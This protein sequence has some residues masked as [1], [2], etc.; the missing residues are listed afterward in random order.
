MLRNFKRLAGL[1]LVISLVLSVFPQAIF[2]SNVSSNKAFLSF[3]VEGNPGVI[4]ESNHTI[5]VTVPYRSAVNNMFESFTISGASVI[6]HTSEMTRTNYTNP[7]VLTVVAEDNSTQD[8]TVTVIIGPSNLKSIT[9]FN[10]TNPPAMGLIDDEAYAVFLTVPQGTDLTQLKPSFTTDGASVQVNGVVQTSGS[11]A[12]DFTQPIMYTVVADDG[13]SRNYLVTVQIQRVLSKAKEFTYFAL[14]SLPATGIIDESSKTISITVPYGTNR[15]ALVPVFVTTGYMVQIYG[16]QQISGEEARNFTTPIIY[17]VLDEGLEDQDYLVTVNEAPQ[18]ARSTK[19]LL[20]FNVGGVDG[21]VNEANHTIAVQVPTGYDRAN[22]TANFTANGQSVRVG[23]QLQI[24]DLSINNFSQPVTY[25]VFAENGLTQD[26]VVSVEL[27]KQIISYDLNYP[28]QVHGVIDEVNKTISFQIPYGTDLSATKAVY[29]TNADHIK[30][31]G[32]VQQSGV[33]ENDISL[34]PTIYAVDSENAAAPYTL[35]LNRALNP[36]KDMTS[37]GLTTPQLNGVIDQNNQTVSLTVPYGTNVSEL[38]PTFAIT[39]TKA[40]VG[41]LDQIS[42]STE[43]DFRSPVTYA[44]YAEDATFKDYLVT[45]KV[46]AQLPDHNSSEGQVS[47]PSIDTAPPTKQPTAVFTSVVNLAKVEEFIKG[48]MEEAKRKSNN[49]EFSDVN[50]HWSK[51]NIDLFIKLGVISGYE[52]NTF[53]PDASITR[54]EFAVIIAK[55]FH[56]EAAD[57]SAL[58]KDVKDHWANKAIAALSS[59]GIITGYEDGMFK[60]DKTISR[61][62]IIAILGRLIDLNATEKHQAASFRDVGS[63]W[64]AKEI[65]AAASSGLVEGRDANTFAPNGSS[66]RAEALTIILRALSLNPG[67]K[68]LLEQ[69]K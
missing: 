31:N 11:T 8:Y 18:N 48:K 30:I 12:Q 13:S 67:V 36:A 32:I 21:I 45:I 40:K 20:T 25:T 64:N 65:E 52:D 6:N 62:E 22:Q 60:P 41:L 53:K 68:S 46:T 61:A 28:I 56:I 14:A 38:I 7:V 43:Q 10:L 9:T 34:S 39:G 29:T 37:F 51:S 4:D 5:S 24:S 35:I 66:T 58:L 49:T 69:F 1:F 50:K 23:N 55:V 33:T 15:A 19:Q 17:T 57:K 2:A 59:N 3:S 54:A 63:S 47:S 44:V 16:Q 27:Q 42:G 26:Y